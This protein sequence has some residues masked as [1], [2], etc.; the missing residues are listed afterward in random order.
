EEIYQEGLRI[1]P[2]K[3]MSGGKM[4]PDVW[5]L[6]LSNVRTP[7]ER[8][9]DLSAMI[10]ANRTGERRLLE[11]VAKYGWNEGHRYVS[12]SIDY[13]E[14]MPRHAISTIPD[15]SYEAEDFLDDDGIR[16]K[17]I[18]IRV[19]IRIRGGSAT[20]DFSKSDPQAEGSVNA[21]Y[22]ITASVVFYVF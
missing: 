18:A 12:E 7:E 11:I 20:I 5:E 8:E 15:G 22:A 4:N 10:G 9:G 16:D 3:L 17:P 21:V 14:L 19:R 13:S 6:V 2:I 1:P